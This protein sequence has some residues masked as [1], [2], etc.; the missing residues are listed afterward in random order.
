MN[1]LKTLNLGDAL[2]RNNGAL[3]IS[4]ALKRGAAS[5]EVRLKVCKY[6]LLNILCQ[7]L[8]VF[9]TFLIISTSSVQFI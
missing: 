4:T 6:C 5:L 1:S 7:S 2:I 8:C 9:L 3:A